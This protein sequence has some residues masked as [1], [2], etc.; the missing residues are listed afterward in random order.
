VLCKLPDAVKY[1]DYAL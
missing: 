1:S